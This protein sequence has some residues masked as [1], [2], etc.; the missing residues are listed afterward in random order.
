ML[1]S[2]FKRALLTFVG[3]MLRIAV[4]VRFA[5]YYLGRHRSA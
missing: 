4:I 1:W 2:F 5:V 3:V